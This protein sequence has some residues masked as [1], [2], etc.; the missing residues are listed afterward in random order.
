LDAQCVEQTSH[1]VNRGSG[2]DQHLNQ[3]K[4]EIRNT[5]FHK[6]IVSADLRFPSRMYRDQRSEL[7][8]I[9]HPQLFQG[10]SVHRRATGEKK[11]ERSNWE[12]K[13]RSSNTPQSDR[14]RPSEKIS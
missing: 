13:A 5:I 2:F 8:R 4:L 14:D 6:T 11:L 10:D 1:G 9:V 7:M 12:I 3:C